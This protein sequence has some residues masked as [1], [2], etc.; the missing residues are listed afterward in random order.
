MSE[1]ALTQDQ[2]SGVK[3]NLSEIFL[4]TL[5]APVA[6]FERLAAECRDD[7]SH[8]SGAIGIVI[9]VFALDALRLTSAAHLNW[10]AL[11]AFF[12]VSGGLTLWLLLSLVAGLTALCFGLPGARVRAAFVTLGWSLLPWLFLSPLAC[13]GKVFGPAEVLLMSV[14]VFWIM[15]LQ[16]LAIKQSFAMKIWQALVFVLLVPPLLA[17]FQVLQFVQSLVATIGSILH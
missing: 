15:I 2:I 6:T 3:L 17:W 4:G 5:V 9:L 13:F 7:G 16:I 10:L 11:N 14:P 12:E 8:L 1:D